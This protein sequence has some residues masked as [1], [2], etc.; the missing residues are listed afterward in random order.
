MMFW[1][2]VLKCETLDADTSAAGQ[3]GGLPFGIKSGLAAERLP[4]FACALLPGVA[5]S[6]GNRA[7]IRQ[8][9]RS[10]PSSLPAPPRNLRQGKFLFHPLKKRAYVVNH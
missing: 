6:S 4:F 9:Q 2:L 5:R 3:H 8:R 1:Q 7:R 10:R